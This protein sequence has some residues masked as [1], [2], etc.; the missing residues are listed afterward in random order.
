MSN[1]DNRIA[2]IPHKVYHHQHHL[3]EAAVVEFSL[4]SHQHRTEL[5]IFCNQYGIEC[6]EQPIKM[7]LS[8]VLIALSKVKP[9]NCRD[10]DGTGLFYQMEGVVCPCQEEGENHL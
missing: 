7:G 6:H 10:C 8:K 1:L 4:T 3:A 9:R 2:H 5:Q